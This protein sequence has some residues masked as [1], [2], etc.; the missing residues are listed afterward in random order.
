VENK[1]KLVL[2]EMVAA[3]FKKFKL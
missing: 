2:I 1:G 3:S